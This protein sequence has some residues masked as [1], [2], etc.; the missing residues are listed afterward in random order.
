MFT[1]LLALFRLYD[2]LGT[3][4]LFPKLYLFTYIFKFWKMIFDLSFFMS[5]VF[6]SLIGISD[7][8]IVV[9]ASLP[10]SLLHTIFPSRVCLLT[11]LDSLDAVLT[12]LFGF[13]SVFFCP[14]FLLLFIFIFVMIFILL[15]I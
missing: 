7:R 15:I 13:V 14:L 2:D 4:F 9:D 12:M 8:F 11:T 6:L 5:S 3:I 1:C 10:L